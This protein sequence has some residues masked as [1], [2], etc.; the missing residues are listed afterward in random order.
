MANAIA[1]DLALPANGFDPD[2]EPGVFFRFSFSFTEHDSNVR[3]RKTKEIKI[4]FIL[5]LE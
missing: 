4:M 2:Q 1:P 5:C 3:L